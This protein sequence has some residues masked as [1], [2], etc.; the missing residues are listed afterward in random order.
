MAFGRIAL[1]LCVCL[2]LGRQDPLIPIAPGVLM[3]YINMGG[4][5]KSP[6]HPDA[7][8]NYSLFLALGGRGLDAALTYGEPLQRQ[9]ARA[10]KESGIPREDIFVTSKIPCCPGEAGEDIWCSDARYNGS[11]ADSIQL[12]I[13]QLGSIDL[14]LLH[15]PCHTVE[16][17]LARYAEMEAALAAGKTRAIGVSNFNASL[18]E[19]LAQV[20]KTPPAVNQ[21]GYSIG[22]HDSFHHPELGGTDK[23]VAYCKE[24]NITYAAYSPLGGLDGLHILTDPTVVAVAASHGVSPAQVCLRWL[25]Q[26]GIQAVTA[27]HDKTYIAEDIDVFSFNLTADEMQLLSAL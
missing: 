26:Q 4:T 25:V 20:A 6:D 19:A 22:A 5:A 3:P 2:A 18:L 11:V 16:A 12:D 8:S 27:A 15:W 24:H 17:T 13:D 14:M 9:V 7:Y 21:C 23:T 10:V 1:S